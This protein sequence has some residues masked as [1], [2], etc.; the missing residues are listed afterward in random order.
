M[1]EP[2]V[3]F[4]T[5]ASSGMGEAQAREALSRGDIVVAAARRIDRLER[6]AAEAPD[7]VLA[8]ELDVT[9]AGSRTRAVKAALERFGRIDVLANIAGRGINGAVEELEIDQVRA[10]FELNFFAAIE[11]TRLVLPHMRARR[12]GCIINMT[13]ICGLVAMPDLGVYCASKFALEAWSEALA[14]EARELGIRVLLVE[15]GGFRTEFEG[16][17]IVRPAQRIAD[18]APVV[19]PIEA[20]LMGSAGA[21]IGDP[22]KAARVIADAAVAAEAPLR[23]ILGPDAHGMWDEYRASVDRDVQAWK[24]RTVDTN[25]S[26]A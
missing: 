6:L 13:S 15:P 16:P 2:N 1:S 22:V 11:L 21:Q 25:I 18:Y 24:V 4:I 19:E 23:L 5:G 12:S 14:G 7:R 8:V 26:P 20:E 3:W 17:A 9:D 10:A